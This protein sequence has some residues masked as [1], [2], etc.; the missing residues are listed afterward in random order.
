[1]IFSDRILQDPFRQQRLCQH[2]FKLGSFPFQFTQALRLIE[3]YLPELFPPTV[4]GHR[5]DIPLLADLHDALAAVRLPQY[6]DL[7][8]CRVTFSFHVSGSFDWTQTHPSAGSISRYHVT[9]FSRS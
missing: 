3:V 5:G 6:A 4:E 2:L 7:V 8:L 9:G 1:M